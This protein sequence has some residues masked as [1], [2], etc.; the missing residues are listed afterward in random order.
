MDR[1]LAES[2]T[3]S[4]SAA[5]RA[6]QIVEPSQVMPCGYGP[7]KIC[8]EAIVHQAAP[9]CAVRKEPPRPRDRVDHRVGAI[10]VEHE[11]VAGAAVEIEFGDGVFKAASRTD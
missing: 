7:G 10:F 8:G 4:E 11:T 3:G 1:F 9:C 5:A 6:T 2:A